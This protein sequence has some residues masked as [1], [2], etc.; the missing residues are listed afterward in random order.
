MENKIKKMLREGLLDED[1]PTS[2]NMDEFK[3]LTSFNKRIKYCEQHLTR[4]GSGSSRIV[5]KIDDDK[6]LKL[7]KN[8]KGLAQNEVE[9]DI[10]ASGWHDDIL[11]HIIDA[12]N[13]NL[14]VEMELARPAKK[15][16]F[17]KIIG[18]D[19]NQIHQFLMNHHTG[20]NGGKVQDFQDEK[21]MEE[22]WELEFVSD[23]LSVL[24][25]WEAHPGDLG[26]TSSYGIVNRNG[27]DEIVIVDYG[28]TGDVVQTYYSIN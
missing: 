18:Y 20:K 15:G 27:T 23:V 8:K 24:D 1:Y 4:L 12:H 7:A 16:D 13:H 14:W 6:V 17:K 11:A 28:I 10:H 25:N 19:L 2:F 3:S 21:L 26:R 5:Y 9:A 22:L